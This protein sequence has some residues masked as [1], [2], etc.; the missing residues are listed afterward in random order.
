MTLRYLV[1]LGFRDQFRRSVV[2]P[3]PAQARQWLI[4][5]SRW[6]AS[7]VFASAER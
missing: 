5:G 6:F 2:V 4:L 7:R 1:Y 3:M